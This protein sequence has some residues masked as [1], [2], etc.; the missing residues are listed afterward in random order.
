MNAAQYDLPCCNVRE[1][2]FGRRFIVPTIDW[3]MN[4]RILYLIG[5][6]YSGGSE[7]QLY[8]LVRSMD[9]SRYRQQWLS[10]IILKQDIY[11]PQIREL[12]VPIY[13]FSG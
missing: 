9:R 12:G 3:L 2:S 4:S 8:Y 11:V 1:T 7:R 5:Q 10:G 13:S 6:L